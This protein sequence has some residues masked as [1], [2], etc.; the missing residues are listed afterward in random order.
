MLFNKM[1]Y[2]NY[3]SKKEQIYILLDLGRGGCGLVVHVLAFY[4]DNAS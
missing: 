1:K 3:F 2:K 4:C